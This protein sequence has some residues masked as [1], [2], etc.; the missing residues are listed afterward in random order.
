LNNRYKIPGYIKTLIRDNPKIVSGRKKFYFYQWRV[1]KTL[2]LVKKYLSSKK[3][4][5]N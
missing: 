1:S 4:L 2:D 3:N 5:K